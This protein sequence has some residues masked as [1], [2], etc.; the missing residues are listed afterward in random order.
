MWL[1]PVR[2]LAAFSR[3]LTHGYSVD[4]ST[5]VLCEFEHG[6]Q[7]VIEVNYNVPDDAAQNSLEIRGTR[8]VVTADHTIGQG[9]GG[10]MTAYL[11]DQGVYAAAQERDKVNGVQPI[12]VQPV[13]PYRAEVEHLAECIHSGQEPLNNGEHAL[14]NLRLCLAA[15]EAARTGRTVEL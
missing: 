8:G 10:N 15:Y 11:Y 9:A 1:G 3:C 7:G 13:N 2:R 6:A 14:H 5:T 4:D 12:W